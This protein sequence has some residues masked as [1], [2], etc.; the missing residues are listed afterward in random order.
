[1]NG[2][3]S[4]RHVLDHFRAHNHN[5]QYDPVL[6]G[7]HGTVFISFFCVKCLTGVP[8]NHLGIVVELFRCDKAYY[9][10]VEVTTGNRL[11]YHVV[12]DDRIAMKIMKEVCFCVPRL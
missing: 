1:M 12:D 2:V 3:D 6:N 10:A 5:G 9:Q 11:F 4:V 8:Y 7:Y